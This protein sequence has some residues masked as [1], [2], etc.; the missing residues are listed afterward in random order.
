MQDLTRAIL[1]MLLQTQE[2]AVRHMGIVV[3][4]QTT[5]GLDAN[6]HLVL[7]QVQQFNHPV[8]R[9]YAE[10]AMQGFPVPE[11]F[12]VLDQDIAGTQPIIAM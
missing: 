7:V 1:V 6:R 5:V 10:P 4:Q 3:T 9:S 12:A 2:D 8:T 11:D